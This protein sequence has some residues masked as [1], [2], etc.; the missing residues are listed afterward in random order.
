[1]EGRD[2]AAI[3]IEILSADVRMVPNLI[4]D[5]LVAQVNRALTPRASHLVWNFSDTLAASFEMP[6]QLEQLQRLEL[7]GDGSF[8]Q[9][10]ANCI[11]LRVAYAFS[12]IRS[13]E[14]ETPEEMSDEGP[15]MKSGNGEG[16][17]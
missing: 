11:V 2:A 17:I 12:V 10:H 7:N 14:E 9:I 13:D 16:S 4:D 1:V 3:P 8:F 6:A 5:L 15:T